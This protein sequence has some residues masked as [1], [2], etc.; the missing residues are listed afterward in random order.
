MNNISDKSNVFFSI[1]NMERESDAIGLLFMCWVYTFRQSLIILH[2]DD[3]RF[4]HHQNY[5]RLPL[6]TG[7]LQADGST[8]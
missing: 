7:G 5:T 6:F 1:E 8:Q 2:V 3:H 4:P